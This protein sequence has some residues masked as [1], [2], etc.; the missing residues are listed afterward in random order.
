M[1]RVLRWTLF[2]EIVLTLRRKDGTPVPT[3]EELVWLA[4]IVADSSDD[5]FSLCTKIKEEDRDGK[6]ALY[7]FTQL[8]LLAQKSS[9][10]GKRADN[11][12]RT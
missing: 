2:S 5:A 1:L 10:C 4:T 7:Y 12:F 3:D 11:K 8:L 6:G 9:P